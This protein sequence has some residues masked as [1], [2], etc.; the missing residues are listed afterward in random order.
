MKYSTITIQECEDKLSNGEYAIISNG[1]VIG[2]E[3]ED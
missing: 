3:R 1:Q 2:F